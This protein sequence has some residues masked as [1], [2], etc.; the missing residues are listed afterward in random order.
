[1]VLVPEH[2]DEDINKDYE[3]TLATV[4]ESVPNWLPV[5]E[6]WKQSP[7]SFGWY[8]LACDIRD[9]HLY[10]SSW[11]ESEDLQTF[12]GLFNQDAF[13]SL[14][15]RYLNLCAPKTKCGDFEVVDV[16]LTYG[17][18]A[19]SIWFQAIGA[20]SI[21]ELPGFFGNFYIRSASIAEE[22]ERYNHLIAKLDWRELVRRGVEFYNAPCSDIENLQLIEEILTAFPKALIYAQEKHCGLLGLVVTAG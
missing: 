9:R 14:F 17:D 12:F 15:F 3:L 11:H 13:Y 19:P 4:K 6:K 22:L 21:A 1:M 10:Y 20:G 18:T 16:V 2:L 8:M 7:E 5:I